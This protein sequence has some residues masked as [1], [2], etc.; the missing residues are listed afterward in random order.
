MSQRSTTALLSENITTAVGREEKQLD[1]DTIILYKYL[2]M[3]I[4]GK[5]RCDLLNSHDIGIH[6]YKEMWVIYVNSWCQVQ[7]LDLI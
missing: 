4:Y 5:G 2:C 3:Y 6:K 1:S 7:T